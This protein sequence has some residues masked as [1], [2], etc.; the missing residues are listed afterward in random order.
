MRSEK[1]YGDEN[2]SGHDNTLSSGKLSMPVLPVSWDHVT[3][4]VVVLIS[5]ST[6]DGKS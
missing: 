5:Q 6:R 3:N 2:V 4:G 1:G